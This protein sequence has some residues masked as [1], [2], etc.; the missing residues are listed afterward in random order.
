MNI[1]NQE[2]SSGGSRRSRI[3]RMRIDQGRFDLLERAAED[4]SVTVDQL[5]GVWLRDRIDQVAAAAMAARSAQQLD[6]LLQ[7]MT[8]AEADGPTGGERERSAGTR[9]K[10]RATRKGSL[11]DEIVEVLRDRGGPM[12]AAE[13]AREIRLRGE[14][15]APRSGQPI[16][17]TAVSRRVANPYYRSLFDREGR[18][19]SLADQARER[20]D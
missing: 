8:G 12:T 2:R 9:T 15:L 4:A 6:H 7:A 13:I 17:G 3:V 5:V 18:R 16:T 11:H 10:A 20:E 19:L 14:Y 1:D